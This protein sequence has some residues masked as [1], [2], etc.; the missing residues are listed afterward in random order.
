MRFR[1]S[2]LGALPFPLLLIIGSLISFYCPFPL[3]LITPSTLSAALLDMSFFLFPRIIG[4]GEGEDPLFYDFFSSN[5]LR[6]SSFESI[7]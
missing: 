4:E 6:L 7:F 2:T 5:Y 3:F 1:S